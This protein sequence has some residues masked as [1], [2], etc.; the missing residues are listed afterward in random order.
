MYTPYECDYEIS[1]HSHHIR[2]TKNSLGV[3]KLFCSSMF[4]GFW[5]RLHSVLVEDLNLKVYN[6]FC[7]I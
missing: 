4:Y 7:E 6:D 5:L 1:Y 2:V 3:V